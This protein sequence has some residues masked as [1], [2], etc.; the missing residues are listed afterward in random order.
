MCQAA[1]GLVG[2]LCRALSNELTKYCDE[3]MD[4]MVDTLSV[5]TNL[6][7]LLMVML[8]AVCNRIL[9]FTEP[10]NLQYYQPL[11]TLH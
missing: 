6:V 3:I 7:T 4:I 10:L 9:W 2:D 5:S 1:V 8:Y 11:V